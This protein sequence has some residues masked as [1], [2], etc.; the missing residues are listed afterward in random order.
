M[1]K[2]FHTRANKIGLPAGS[3][4]HVGEKLA[5]KT[6]I[7]VIE[8]DEHQFKEREFV[9]ISD[10]SFSKEN[11]STTWIN[12]DGLHDIQIL[13]QLGKIF[14]IHPLILEDILNTDQRPKM[15]DLDE[16]LYIVLRM[17]YKSKNK[18]DVVQSEQ[19]SFI[20]GHNFI[21]SFQEKPGDIFDP[22]R[23]RIKNVKGRIRKAGADF[24]AYSLIDSIV[25]YYFIVLESL[26]EKIE[27]FEN[28]LVSSPSRELLLDIQN[29][30]REIIFLRKFAWP[31]RETVS[32]LERSES[33]LIQESTNIYFKDIY[34]HTI[35]VIDTIEIFRE[36]LS[37]MLDIY[38]SSI[39]NKMNEIM[40]VLTI[41]ATI[42]MPLTFIAG[43]YG[44]N[45]KYMPEL[46]W[47]WGYPMI[48]GITLTISSIMLIYFKKKKWL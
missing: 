36:T 24:L 16:Y 28:I 22:I 11:P 26:D 47:R 34:D 5:D 27:F 12:I 31:M 14:N 30:K 46:G 3:L 19:V 6:K 21:I 17:F 44:M 9:T 1:K 13:E 23:D 4:I 29:L 43:I 45:F 20:I 48:W 37:S 25:D 33:P 40:K 7:T 41:I 10:F 18:N 39:S 38:L 8:Y 42:F 32:L 15:E 2:G 35:Q